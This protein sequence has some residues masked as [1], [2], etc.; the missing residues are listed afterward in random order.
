MIDKRG[1]NPL[2]VVPPWVGGLGLG[3]LR[4]Q[5]EQAREAGQEAAP[6]HGLSFSSCFQAPALLELQPRLPK[7]TVIQ[8]K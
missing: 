2:W 5:A 6:L 3:S 7:G 1:P 4:E 8:D